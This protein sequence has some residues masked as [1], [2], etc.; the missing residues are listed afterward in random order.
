MVLVALPGVG[1]GVAQPPALSGSM[2]LSKLL[3][4]VQVLVVELTNKLICV[5]SPTLPA[6]SVARM[7]SVCA[8]MVKAVVS[9][10]HSPVVAS[11]VAVPSSVRPS[12]TLTVEPGVAVP[13][14]RGVSSVNATLPVP[15]ALGTKTSGSAE[16]SDTLTLLTVGSTTLETTV[17]LTSMLS[18]QPEL[19]TAV[20]V[21]ESA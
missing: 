16:L 18:I 10:N 11:A 2:A 21:A 4:Q 9:R 8:P 12:Y 14:K 17:E 15:L 20:P 19:G 7:S 1:F 6:V 13:C 3:L 5:F